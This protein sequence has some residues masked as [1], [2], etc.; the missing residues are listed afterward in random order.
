[1]KKPDLLVIVAVWELVTAF[2][3]LI[4]LAVLAMIGFQVGALFL[5]D[6]DLKLSGPFLYFGLAVG[7]MILL[8]YLVVSIAGA[9]GLLAERN[10]GRVTSLVHGVISLLFFPIGTVIGVLQI[11]YLTRADVRDFFQN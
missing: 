2:F 1:M 10:F 6:F 8:A 5:G 7:A 4:G 9:S 11:I 3:A